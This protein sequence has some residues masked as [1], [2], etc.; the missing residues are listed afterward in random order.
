LGTKTRIYLGKI[1]EL[2]LHFHRNTFKKDIYMSKRI[3]SKILDKHSNMYHFTQY[4]NFNILTNATI[5]SCAY[6]NCKKTINFIAHIKEED[7]YILYSLKNERNHTICNTIF[8]LKKETLK[9]YYYRDDFKLF[10]NE[11][12]SLIEEYIQN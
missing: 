9:K 12:Q 6:D 1:I 3:Q 10:K 5:G 7:K 4:N 8:S 11:Y 2:I